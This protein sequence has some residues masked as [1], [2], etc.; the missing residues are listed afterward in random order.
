MAKLQEWMSR[1]D[2]GAM[3]G[4][5]LSAVDRL[6]KRAGIS[7]HHENVSGG[8][9]A[10]TFYRKSEITALVNERE[11]KPR[12]RK[13]S[14]NGEGFPAPTG[15]G[16]HDLERIRE[17]LKIRE[18]EGVLAQADASARYVKEYLTLAEAEVHSG[19]PRGQLI[20]LIKTSQV[21]SFGGR[22]HVSW[23]IRRASLE[24]WGANERARAAS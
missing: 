12:D 11:G 17:H 8:G 4:L 3:L 14:V 6:V 13:D 22:T 18:P 15:E 21:D 7:K 9:P 16:S 10:Q 1:K 23:R 19:I 5:S 24:S 2:A 20:E